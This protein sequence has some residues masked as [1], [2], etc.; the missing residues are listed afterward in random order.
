MRILLVEDDESIIEVVTAILDAQ[1][2]ILDIAIEGDAGWDLAE[3]FP[4]DLILLDIGLP[5]LDGISFCRRLR[6]RK[7]QAL[8]M[9]LTARDTM[10]DKL[11]GLEAGADDYV[12]KPFNVQELAARIRVLLRRGNPITESVL[13][14]G[15][16]ALDPTA[17]EVTYKGQL[18]RFS[19][20]EYLLLELF[21]RHQHRVFSRSAIVDQ[22][23]SFNEDPPNEDTVKSHIKS[24]RRK[25]DAVGVGNLIETLYG[26]GY[27][28]NPIYLSQTT[29]PQT[30]QPQTTQ[31]GQPTADAVQRQAALNASVQQTWQ[32]TKGLNLERV[33][34]LEQVMRA[35]KAG[36]CAATLQQQGMQNAHK[37]TGSLGTFGFESSSQLAQQ[38][39]ELLAESDLSTA[40]QKQR[41][42]AMA[43]LVEALSASLAEERLTEPVQLVSDQDLAPVLVPGL[44]PPVLPPLVAATANSEPFRSEPGLLLIVSQTSPLLSSL[45][46]AA[47]PK[48]RSVIVQTYPE[49]ESYLG[50][51]PL[52]V[53]VQAANWNPANWHSSIGFLRQLQQRAIPVALL[54]DQAAVQE[55][56][57]AIQA[58]VNLFLPADMPVQAMLTAI[59]ELCP[60]SH[61]PQSP[62]AKVLLVD[63]DPIMAHLLSNCLQ[64]HNIHVTSLQEPLQ[65]WQVLHQVQPDLLILDVKMPHVD[66]IELCQTVRCDG[67]WRWLPIVFLTS[68]THPKIQQQIFLAGADDLVFKP[69]E[70]VELSTR[71]LNRL[72]RAQ[73]LTTRCNP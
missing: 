52:V 60:W 63:D 13:T 32:R 54:I 70:P 16:L 45:A 35:L 33:T 67:Q 71:I 7:N 58:G 50:Q 53:L 68:Q 30:T 38:I 5:K 18:L 27:R 8:V 37:L 21:L 11:I 69:I 72:R 41:A 12:V 49:A 1:G 22:I 24:I 19:R 64:P 10:T 31:S 9:L 29:Q 59:E 17:C 47:A 14:C 51:S 25:L 15:D 39:E 3:A 26:Q 44:A 46:A 2:Y 4:Y 36:S 6:E 34:L 48:F 62:T 55:R 66:G 57:L 42:I 43:P 40:A 73:L 28:I 61:S 20:K 56:C 65:F 23:W